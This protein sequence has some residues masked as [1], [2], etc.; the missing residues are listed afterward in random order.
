MHP[1]PSPFWPYGFGSGRHKI[2]KNYRFFKLLHFSGVLANLDPGSALREMLI[3]N[4]SRW[5]CHTLVFIS[6]GNVGTS[7]S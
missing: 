7:A 2:G 1:V 3:L 5:D 6:V 4:T